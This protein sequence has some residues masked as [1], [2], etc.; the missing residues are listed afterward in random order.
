MGTITDP[1]DESTFTEIGTV[2]LTGIYMDYQEFE[3]FFTDYTGTDNYIAIRMNPNLMY[4]GSYVDN[5]FI[6]IAPT[7][8]KPTDLYTV[9]TT[10]NSATIGWTENGDATQWNIEYGEIGFT[11]TGNVNAIATSNPFEL[12]GLLSSTMYDFYVQADC[13]GGDVS[14]WVGPSSFKTLCEATT[15]PYFE[16]FEDAII[17]EVPPCIIVE[18]TNGDDKFWYTD[19][20]EPYEG[21]KTIRINYNYAEAMDDWFFSAPLDL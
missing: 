4:Q 9:S 8:P 13:G 3:V 10:L 5:M 20:T 14:Y 11:P 17:P 19:T 1:S 16:G 15:V 7:C 2:N 18:N 12:T 6:D 21:D